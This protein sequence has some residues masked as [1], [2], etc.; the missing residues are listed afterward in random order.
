MTDL[1]DYAPF[2]ATAPVSHDRLPFAIGD[3]GQAFSLNLSTTPHVLIGGRTGSG[4]TVAA[5][6]IVASGLRAGFDVVVADAHD[7]SIHQ[8]TGGE[9][10]EEFRARGL[11]EFLYELRRRLDGVTPEAGRPVL[12]VIDDV[13]DMES[14]RTP[15]TV[16]VHRAIWQS[17]NEL[18][19]R[20]A[21][22]HFVLRVQAASPQAMFRQYVSGRAQ[23][24]IGRLLLGPSSYGA[25]LTMFESSPAVVPPV[26]VDA[27]KGRGVFEPAWRSR[28][29]GP[30]LIQVWQPPNNLS[31]DM[32]P[33]NGAGGEDW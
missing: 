11:A 21:G 18:I 3:D 25:Q 4:G 12:V 26:D 27:P 1:P 15:D 2:D 29:S 5:Q 20:E 23:D 32:S 13:Q 22:V 24:S 10:V 30:R 6:A 19:E 9:P 28:D 14:D 8:V 31:T 17:V 16:A 33:A 7:G